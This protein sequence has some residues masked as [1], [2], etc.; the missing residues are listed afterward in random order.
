MSKMKNDVVEQSGVVRVMASDALHRCLIRG[1]GINASG[2]E[3]KVSGLLGC[4]GT[5]D[6][7][8]VYRVL[9]G[10]GRSIS[11]EAEQRGGRGVASILAIRCRCLP[12][13][14]TSTMATSAF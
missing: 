10:G 3:V 14:S 7:S 2:G 13:P 8:G 5:G 6:L 11:S 9:G 12:P 1:E 4:D